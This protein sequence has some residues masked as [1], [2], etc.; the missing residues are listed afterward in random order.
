[1]QG[2]TGVRPLVEQHIGAVESGGR[3]VL[4]GTQSLA[5]GL[6]LPGALC[7]H[8]VLVSL[9]FASNSSPLESALEEVLGSRY[10]ED[11]ALQE[12]AIKLVQ[13]TGRLARS[14]SDWGRI[15]ML[16]HRLQTK[17][18]GKKLRARLPHY[19]WKVVDW[20]QKRAHVQPKAYGPREPLPLRT[21]WPG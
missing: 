16:D 21:G 6:D 18:Y 7:M 15:T 5:E 3:S 8:V 4:L 19:E 17:G 13:M 2:S 12:V 20:S 1:M 14:P 9:P 11:R 10:F